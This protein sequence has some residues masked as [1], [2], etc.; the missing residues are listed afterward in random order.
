MNDYS[1]KVIEAS[2]EL[3]AYHR[4]K[5]KDTSNA[6]KLDTA[7]TDEG[8]PLIITP[9]DYAILQVHNGKSTKN[10][11]YENYMILDKDGNKYVTGSPSFWSAFMEIWNE[12]KDEETGWQ[13]GVYKMPSKNYN[14]KSFITCSIV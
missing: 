9:V 4:V 12:M 14:G 7:V 11:D 10:P 2:C 5:L 3:D 1:V 8:E 13:I 6:I